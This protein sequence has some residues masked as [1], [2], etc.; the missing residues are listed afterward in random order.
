MN[1]EMISRKQMNELEHGV[2]ELLNT[3]RKAK[4]QND[5]LVESL[6]ALELGLGNVRR[7]R[8]DEV[9]TEYHTY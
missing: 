3:I 9:N 4:L 2:R 5:P 8:F 6:K 1:L 7:E